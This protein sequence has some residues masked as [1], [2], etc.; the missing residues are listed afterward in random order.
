MI[1]GL[2]QSLAQAVKVG[3]IEL[4]EIKPQPTVVGDAWTSAGK[5]F[6]GE[7]RIRILRVGPC[8]DASRLLPNPEPGEVWPKCSDVRR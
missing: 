2:D 6:G 8:R 5:Q 1:P 4:R 3:L 7:R